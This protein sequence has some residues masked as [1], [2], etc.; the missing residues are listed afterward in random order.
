MGAD[1]I[2]IQLALS[3]KTYQDALV[4]ILSRNLEW[5]VETVY[6]PDFKRE[7]L[8]VIDDVI[9][10]LLNTVIEQPERVVIVASGKQRIL[11]QAWRCGIQAIIPQDQPPAIVALSIMSAAL[12]Y[13]TR[14]SRTAS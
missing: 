10:S 3:D 14:H 9:F 13:L 4:R 8:V 1:K 11:T 7:G 12:R 6:Q 2:H 5:E